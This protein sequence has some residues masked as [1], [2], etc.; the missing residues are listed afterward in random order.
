[1]IHVRCPDC[2]DLFGPDDAEDLV[3]MPDGVVR[4]VLCAKKYEPWC[5]WHGPEPTL[6]GD[7]KACGECLHVWRTEAEWR[8]DVERIDAELG[9]RPG[10]PDYDMFFCPLCSHDF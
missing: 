4:C 5:F 9:G 7:Y 2:Y 8:A 10:G 6:P 1:M 3:P